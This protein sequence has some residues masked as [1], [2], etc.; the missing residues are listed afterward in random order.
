MHFFIFY[1]YLIS[2]VFV[3]LTKYKIKN[4]SWNEKKRTNRVSDE[5]KETDTYL[6]NYLC[7]LEVTL[8]FLILVAFFLIRLN[9]RQ[10]Y[11]LLLFYL[12]RQFKLRDCNITP[13]MLFDTFASSNEGRLLNSRRSNMVVLKSVEFK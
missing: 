9:R 6:K 1:H 10:I 5:K 8:A 4:D 11:N 3:F 12:R 2:I 13:V 7:L